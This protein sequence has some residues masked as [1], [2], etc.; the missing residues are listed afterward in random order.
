MTDKPTDPRQL[1]GASHDTGNRE[2]DPVT[3]YDTTGHEW[4]SIR[5]LNTPFPKIALW[6]MIATVVYSVIAWIL[7]PAWPSASGYTKG[8]LGLTQEGQAEK[9]LRAIKDHRR[10]LTESF[11]G[12][13][14][15]DALAGD[16]ALMTEARTAAHRLFLDNCAACHGVTAAGGPGFPSLNSGEWL[17]GGDP[18]TLVETITVGINSLH[19]D[20]RIAE[21][22]AFDYLEPAELSA[23]A[24]WVSRLPQGTAG[25]DE[26]AAQV[27][28]DNCASCHGDG[29]IGGVGVGAPSLTDDTFIYG[30]DVASVMQTLRRGRKGEMPAWSPRLTEADI[31]ML[32][33]YVADLKAP[34]EKQAE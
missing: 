26:P 9:G 24:S 31:N 28:A 11:S 16:P 10:A 18:Q 30:Q 23:L 13:P 14:D 33:V 22:P 21:M 6:F 27:F 19:P 2:I 7:L 29:G 25:P 15:F 32:A 34:D 12:Q 17:W 8:L 4:G 20:S 1:P 3:G 5:E